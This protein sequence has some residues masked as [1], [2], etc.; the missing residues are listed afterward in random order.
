MHL[1]GALNKEDA[2]YKI[3][4]REQQDHADAAQNP[5][6]VDFDSVHV[7]RRKQILSDAA[8]LE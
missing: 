6:E 5:D 4:N 8:D 2:K 7:L 1:R 3:N